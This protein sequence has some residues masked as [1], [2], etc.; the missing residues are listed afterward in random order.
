MSIVLRFFPNGEFTKGISAVK[1]RDKRADRR[2]PAT[3][4]MI[5]VGSLRSLHWQ[6]RDVCV[7]ESLVPVEPGDEFADMNGTVYTYLCNDFGMQTY[8]FECT[9]GRVGTLTLEDTLQRH[10]AMK[11]LDPIGLSTGRILKEPCVSRKKCLKMTGS[12]ARNIR[13][14]SYLLEQWFG[15]DQLSFLTL[16]VPGV[17]PDALGSICY[18]WDSIVHRFFMWLRQALNSKGIEPLFVYCTEI[19]TARL[20]LRH[21]FAPHIHIL[22]R[23]RCGKKKPWAISPTQARRAWVR[24]LKSCI[25]ES[26]DTRAIENIQR[27]KKSASGYLSK[28]MSKGYCTL[29]ETL[30]SDAPI[31]SLRTHW[32]G[33]SRKLSQAI[34]KSIN[35]IKD[36]RGGG[37]DASAFM[38]NI[39]GLLEQRLV[40]FWREEL[41]VFSGDSSSGE[42]RGL[43]VGYGRLRTP[44]YEGGLVSVYEYIYSSMPPEMYE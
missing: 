23:G 16:T 19:Q 27:I 21:E 31:T 40:V 24:C 9:D 12:M 8:A 34:S 29:P 6:G 43:K 35:I 1:C 26:F 14:A 11:E 18:H 13:N 25:S 10:I 20:K 4:H 30:D 41:V 2:H 39:P 7:R 17:S 5:P 38:S 22:F 44:T 42:A 33:M 3:E 37:K 15:K 36:F 32:G 28:Y